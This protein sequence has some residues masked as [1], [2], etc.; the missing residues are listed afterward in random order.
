MYPV[1][2]LI[3]LIIFKSFDIQF[4][5]ILY[6]SN[7]KNVDIKLEVVDVRNDLFY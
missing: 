4:I 3:R 5:Y 1:Y 6:N 2:L 7:K